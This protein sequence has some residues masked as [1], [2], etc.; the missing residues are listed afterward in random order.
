MITGHVLFAGSEVLA[1]RARLI[2]LFELIVCCCCHGVLL[3]G[4]LS[5]AAFSRSASARWM[6]SSRDWGL[7]KSRNARRSAG[8][9]RPKASRKSVNRAMTC[10][11]LSAINSFRQP[12]RH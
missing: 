3:L 8:F 5:L 1:D 9:A 11:A 4:L 2:D 7:M 6:R 10:E 12:A